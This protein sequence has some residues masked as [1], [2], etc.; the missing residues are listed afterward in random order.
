M[1]VYTEFFKLTDRLLKL[2]IKFSKIGAY[3]VSTQNNYRISIHQQQLEA[4]NFKYHI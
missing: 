3:N 1:S 4:K 2:I